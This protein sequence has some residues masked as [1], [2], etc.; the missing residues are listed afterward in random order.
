[1][2]DFWMVAVWAFFFFKKQKNGIPDN[3]TYVG[4]TIAFCVNSRVSFN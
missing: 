2:K 3:L 1:L 4:E